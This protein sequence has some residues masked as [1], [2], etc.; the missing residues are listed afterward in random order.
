MRSFD[1]ALDRLRERRR[2]RL[3]DTGSS[4]VEG[5]SIVA[6]SI[7][8]QAPSTDP[9]ARLAASLPERYNPAVKI[10]R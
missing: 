2:R 10:V 8:T 4:W 5:S 1:D 3:F 9:I 6:S 7:V